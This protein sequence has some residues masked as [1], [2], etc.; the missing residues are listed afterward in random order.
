M[1]FQKI[2]NFFKKRKKPES[3]HEQV[4]REKKQKYLFRV[5]EEASSPLTSRGKKSGI[6]SRKIP[7]YSPDHTPAYSGFFQKS[8]DKIIGIQD[9]RH[10]MAGIGILLFTLILYIIFV[11]PYFRVNPGKIIIEPLTQGIDPNIVA[12]SAEIVHGSNIFLLNEEKLAKNIK[13]NL[14]NIEAITIDRLMP[15]GIKILVKSLPIHFDA[16]IFD[17]ENKRFWLSNNGV[18]IPL[19]DLKN[20]DFTRHLTLISPELKTELFPSYKKIFTDKKIFIIA[21]I[22]EIFEKEWTD[23]KIANANYFFIENEL[24][25]ILE[26]NVKIILALQEEDAT[27]GAEFSDNLISQ[28]ITLQTYIKN[29][30]S[31]LI[32]GNVHYLDI[33]IPWKVFACADV[34][35]CRQNLISIY[36]KIYEN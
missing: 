21:K 23:L 24:H 29:N 12:R 31:K 4:Q 6:F 33:R 27:R 11:S 17:V 7:K 1:D 2:K 5:E 19:T 32:D 16:T 14:Q 9:F 34:A 15:N 8:L 26:S 3:F 10:I 30:R 13:E 25:I 22:F 35:V 18:L 28:I 20:P 36:G